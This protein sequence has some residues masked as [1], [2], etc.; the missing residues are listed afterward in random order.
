MSATECLTPLERDALREALRSPTRSLVRMGRHYVAQHQRESRSGVQKVRMF[1][2][3]LV[4]MLDRDGLVE[5]DPPQFP[6]RVVLNAHGVAL[7]EQL[8]TEDAA[9][10][11]RS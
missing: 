10:A 2:G 7:A 4:N 8:A 6:D 3:R 11:V 9:R 5:F 1:T